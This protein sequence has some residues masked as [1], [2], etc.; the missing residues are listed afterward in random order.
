MIT[1]TE[2]MEAILEEPYILLTDKKI[3]AIQD[4]LPILEKVVQ[5]GKSLLIIAED[6]EGKLWQLWLS[7]N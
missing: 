1:D 4:I 3:A 6:V 2:K 7:T 5:S